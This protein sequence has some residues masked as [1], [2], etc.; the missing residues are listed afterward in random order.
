MKGLY[1]LVFYGPSNSQVIQKKKRGIKATSLIGVAE[2]WCK[3]SI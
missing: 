1:K 2:V 3:L